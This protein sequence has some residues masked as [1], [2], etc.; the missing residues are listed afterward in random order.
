MPG[1]LHAPTANGVLAEN[2]EL[3]FAATL[4]GHPTATNLIAAMGGVWWGNQ[5]QPQ[6]KPAFRGGAYG[7]AASR[8]EKTLEVVRA[9]E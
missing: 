7:C 8:P 2:R 3:C 4:G 1:G 5:W 6:N 9:L